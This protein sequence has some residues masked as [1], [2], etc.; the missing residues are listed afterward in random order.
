M[1]LLNLLARGFRVIL[2]NNVFHGDILTVWGCR[3]EPDEVNSIQ[4]ILSFFFFF[5]NS[6]QITAYYVQMGI[7][8]TNEDYG[9]VLIGP[10]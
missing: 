4:Y 5:L 1:G 3:G 8:Q 10:F 6:G 7:L 9:E 2:F